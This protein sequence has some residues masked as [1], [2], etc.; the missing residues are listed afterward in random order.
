MVVIVAV[1]VVDAVIVDHDAFVQCSYC[2]C[3]YYFE[4]VDR[5]LYADLLLSRARLGWFDYNGQL[6]QISPQLPP[7]ISI[8]CILHELYNMNYLCIIFHLIYF[9]VNLLDHSCYTSM[10]L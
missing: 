6:Q 2:C 8:T 4:G 10:T 7:V 9:D 5:C 1:D 3:D